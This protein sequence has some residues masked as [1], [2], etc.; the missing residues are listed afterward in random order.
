MQKPGSNFS[1][2]IAGIGNPVPTFIKRRVEALLKAGV[3]INIILDYNESPLELK[4]PALSYTRIYRLNKSGWLQRIKVLLGGLVRMLASPNKFK[5]LYDQ[6][7]HS[8]LRNMIACFELQHLVG[9]KA[10]VVHVQWLS[11]ALR[12]SGLK[13]LS[14]ARLISSARGSQVTVYPLV[15]PH[16]N[17]FLTR[18]FRVCDLIHCVSH[19]IRVRCIALGA[20][21]EKVQ[22]NYNGINTDKFKPS[23]DARKAEKSAIKLITVGALMWRKGVMLQLLIV[24]SLVERGLSCELQVIGQGEDFA[25]LRYYV[26][27]LG[28]EDYVTFLGRKDQPEVIQLLQ[29]ADIYLSTS[30]AEGLANSVLEASATGL[31]VVAFDCEGMHEV[32]VANESG[33]IVPFGRLELFADKV[34]LLAEDKS[35]RER[36]SQRALAHVREKFQE[37]YWVGEMIK[38]YGSFIHVNEIKDQE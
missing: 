21:P 7:E 5:I 1:L 6:Q 4:H 9:V 34:V 30:A 2:A 17:E 37:A 24:K 11:H 29:Q 16:Y 14:D 23:T 38:I 15:R 19:D 10:D 36:Y 18:V 20:L 32:I 22:V 35:L 3:T 33:F 27:L 13:A 12:F 26:E 25:G 31:P 8:P 28:I